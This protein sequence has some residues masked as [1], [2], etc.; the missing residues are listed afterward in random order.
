MGPLPVGVVTRNLA[1]IS[2]SNSM[3]FICDIQEKFRNNIQYFDGLVKNTS[4]V[5]KASKILNLP[6]ICT[7][8]YPKGTIDK[9]LKTS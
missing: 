3:L 6:A 4:T 8:Q 7:E 9:S 2:S 5:I 1:R